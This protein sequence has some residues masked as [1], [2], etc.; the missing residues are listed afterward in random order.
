MR[1]SEHGSRICGGTV[2]LCGTAWHE[3]SA[4]EMGVGGSDF[5]SGNSTK[6]LDQTTRFE[7]A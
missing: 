7:K 2:R 6:S 4:D 3:K 5:G 1:E